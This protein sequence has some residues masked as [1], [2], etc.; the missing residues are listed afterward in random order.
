[1]KQTINN[2]SQFRDEFHAMGRYENFSYE[3]L[4]LLFDYLE[5]LNP[6]YE[7]DVIELCCEYTESTPDE[8]VEA[9]GIEYDT[10]EPEASE[11]A[12]AYLE[13][14]TIIVGTTSTG[15]IVYASNF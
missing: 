9:Y 14:N 11:A 13:A 1:M 12:T 10:D 3:G 8:I 4:E 15:A 6:D 7:L 5:E 2:A